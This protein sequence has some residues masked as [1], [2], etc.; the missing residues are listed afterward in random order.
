MTALWILT[1]LVKV[2]VVLSIGL[3]VLRSSPRLRAAIRH[4]FLVGLFGVAVALP[5]GGW[6]LPAL[7]V[8]VP[9]GAGMTPLP[10]RLAI[11]G[12][13]T[14]RLMPKVQRAIATEQSSDEG[15]GITQVLMAVA[16]GGALVAF[17]PIVIGI[18]QV[19][20]L[21]A[22]ARIWPRGQHLTSLL[23]REVGI[24]RIIEVR[25]HTSLPCPVM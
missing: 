21:R 16:F 2:T 12:D 13:T 9:Y 6:V 4:A 17:V 15:V 18:W 8:N 10:V 7:K 14:E 22:S 5:I 11:A 20:R 24:Q 25:L 1:S 3:G 23:M 19:R